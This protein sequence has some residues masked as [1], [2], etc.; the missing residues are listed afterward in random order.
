MEAVIAPMEAAIASADGSGGRRGRER[1]QML[2]RRVAGIRTGHNW[3]CKFCAKHV[4]MLEIDQFISSRSCDAYCT[5]PASS[6][7]TGTN[8]TELMLKQSAIEPGAAEL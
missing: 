1:G 2:T 4:E 8:A 6:V 3:R 7:S 5:A